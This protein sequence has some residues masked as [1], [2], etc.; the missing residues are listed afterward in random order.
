MNRRSLTIALTTW[1]AAIASRKK[2]DG[3]GVPTLFEQQ[4]FWDVKW[5][6]EKDV[7]PNP[8]ALRRGTVILDT[9][10][11]LPVAH[12]RIVDLG[13][14][15][16]WLT[17]E[18]GK[19][20]DVVGVD[21]S[22]RAITIARS[23]YPHINFLA[24]NVLEMAL[25]AGQFDVAVSLE[26][27]AHV[28]DQD[29]YLGCASKVLRPGGYLIVTTVNKFVYD[30]MDWPPQPPGHIEQWLDR[31]GLKRL[32]RPYFRVLWT[33]SVLPMGHRG[34]LRMINSHKLNTVMQRLTSA[35][36]LEVLKERAGLGWT[37]VALAQKPG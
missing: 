17:A 2:L 1:I 28:E 4:Q 22:E 26:V 25:P 29:G 34:I 19:R 12:P 37:L 20:G 10:S 16:G 33:T 36:S 15:T 32:L 21:L 9:L 23:R 6:K 14:G 13:C 24:G 27:I 35:R 7:Y 11:S 30:R 31:K 8:W 18:L 3:R 5:E